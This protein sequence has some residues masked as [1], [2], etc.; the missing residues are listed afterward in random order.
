[1]LECGL[2]AKIYQI[3]VALGICFATLS[4]L[5]RRPIRLAGNNGLN[6]A[7]LV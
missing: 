7:A 2:M 3:S 4:P 5:C 1:M 6:F